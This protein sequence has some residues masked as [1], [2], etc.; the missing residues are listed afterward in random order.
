[1]VG[2]FIFGQARQNQAQVSFHGVDLKCEAELGHI[3][4]KRSGIARLHHTERAE[5]AATNL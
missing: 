1:M 2:S 4:A 3:P 5:D